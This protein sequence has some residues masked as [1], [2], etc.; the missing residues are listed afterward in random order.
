MAGGM[1]IPATGGSAIGVVVVGVPE[2]IVAVGVAATVI[3]GPGATL[4]VP[5]E[6]ADMPAPVL[7]GGTLAWPQSGRG[8]REPG[9]D[10]PP[11]CVDE[12]RAS[13]CVARSSEGVSV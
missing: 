12:P 4:V 1:A 5:A 6:G 9:V 3:I 13:T 2:A 8:L 11:A 7:V 10:A